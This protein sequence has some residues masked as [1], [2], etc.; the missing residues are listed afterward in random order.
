MTTPAPAPR[1]LTRSRVV[2]AVAVAAV[3]ALAVLA[4]GLLVARG[5]GLTHL[6]SG[7][8]SGFNQLHTGVLGAITTGVYSVF[9]PIPAI[10]LTAVA[11]LLIW[12]F[13]RRFT[14]AATFA[15]G[16][17]LTW[18]PSAVVKAIVHRTRPDAAALPHPFHSQPVDAS[19]PSGH[20]VF[21][22]SVVVVVFLLAPRGTARLVAG[23][24]GALA[25]VAVGMSVLI[26]GVHYPSDVLA[27]ILWALG[28][29]PLVMLVWRAALSGMVASWSRRAS[30]SSVSR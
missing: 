13:S 3:V 7:V 21:V 2:A 22:T 16:I 4:F 9:S 23:V 19:Y 11:T 8:V 29:A 18:L 12:G 20:E 30:S 1:P 5:S 10:A 17:A 24:V 27:S 25:I 28:V 15:V 14:L 6:E 26:D